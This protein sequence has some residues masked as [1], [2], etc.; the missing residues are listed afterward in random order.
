MDIKEKVEQ[1]QSRL[2]G[3]EIE[4]D[5]IIERYSLGLSFDN[6]FLIE[7]N[8]SLSEGNVSLTINY[9]IDF[10]APFIDEIEALFA[11]TFPYPY[12]RGV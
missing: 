5:K 6:C 12:G 7:V 8:Y 10:P 1:I 11:K 2:V 9:D 4:S 3:F